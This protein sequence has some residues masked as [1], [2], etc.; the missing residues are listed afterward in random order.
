MVIGRRNEE[1]SSCLDHAIQVA[2][3]PTSGELIWL[4]LTVNAVNRSALLH[5]YDFGIFSSHIACLWLLCEWLIEAGRIMQLGSSSGCA[6]SAIRI[7]LLWRFWWLSKA[8]QS[9]FLSSL[10]LHLELIP[11]PSLRH[12][13]SQDVNLLVRNE[14]DSSDSW[15]AVR[16]DI[17]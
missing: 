8:R 11:S 5:V 13:D 6:W 2:R 4:R 9:P 16:R 17:L 12:Q 1:N 14:H 10:V 15:W 7:F 3:R